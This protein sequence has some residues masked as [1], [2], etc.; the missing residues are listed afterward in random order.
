MLEQLEKS[1]YLLNNMYV[2][3]YAESTRTNIL[4]FWGVHIIY[5]HIIY[6]GYSVNNIGKN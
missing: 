2:L 6:V 1:F 4:Y 3:T 5:S